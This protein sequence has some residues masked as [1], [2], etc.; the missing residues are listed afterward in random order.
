MAK[1]KPRYDD[2]FRASAIVMLEASGYPNREG[3]LSQ[4]AKHIGIPRMTLQRW[5]KATQNPPPHE[6]VTEK[7]DELSDLLEK[8]IRAALAEMDKARPDTSYRDLGTV[9]GILTDKRQLLSG[10]PTQNNSTKVIIEYA[11]LEIDP[12]QAA[13]ESSESDSRGT[14]L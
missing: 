11:D 7:R 5:A 6:L 2:K 8:E 1:T 3:A 10:E 12:T 9:V 14:A 13:L 4:V